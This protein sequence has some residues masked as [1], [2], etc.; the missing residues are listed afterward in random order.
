MRGVIGNGDERGQRGAQ[1]SQ[2]V[3]EMRRAIRLVTAG[4]TSRGILRCY[5][6]FALFLVY[7]RGE[8]GFIT[9]GVSTKLDIESI[10][11]SGVLVF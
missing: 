10:E 5:C 7:H 4:E 8:G 9:C 1:V 3:R 6:H 2:S 11:I